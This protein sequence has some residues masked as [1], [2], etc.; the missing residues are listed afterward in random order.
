MTPILQTPRL[1]L[2]PITAEHTDPL[3]RMWTTA[4][5][6]QYLFDDEILPWET[7]IELVAQSESAFASGEYGLW[8]AQDPQTQAWVGFTGYW[9]FF[10]PPQIQLLF[11]LDPQ[12]WGRGFAQEMAQPLI[13]YGFEHYGFK[14]ILADCDEPNRRSQRVLEILGFQF[15][16][17]HSHN[18]K[19]TLHYLLPHPSRV[20]HSPN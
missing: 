20:R 7:V 5:V 3:H 16:H 12:F 17:R 11:G 9:P 4:G 8:I 14:W 15:Q 13:D 1:T 18:G 6:R 19:P 10:D 2:V